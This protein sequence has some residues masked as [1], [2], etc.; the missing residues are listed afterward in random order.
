MAPWL[1]RRSNGFLA[2]LVAASFLL[3]TTLTLENFPADPW[4][5]RFF[6]AEFGFF[7]LGIFAY[8]L[9][10]ALKTKP[11]PRRI[12]WTIYGFYLSFLLFYQWLP[13]IIGKEIFLYAATLGSIPFLFL[14]TKKVHFDRMIGELSYPIYIAHGTIILLTEY[15]SG[16]KH[17]PILTLI[18]TV[19]FCLALNKLVAD[20]IERYRQKR[21]L[22][23]R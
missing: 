14:L 12:L 11:I 15:F 22:A 1:V 7:L 20:P 10:A 3:R 8:R 21:V 16:P 23:S 19:L 13:G 2:L 6:P 17:L 5:Q 9:Y 4:K 18:G